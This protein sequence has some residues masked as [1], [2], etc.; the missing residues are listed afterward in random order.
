M[1]TSVKLVVLYKDSRREE[2]VYPVV[3]GLLTVPKEAFSAVNYIEIHAAEFTAKIGD[4]GYFLVPN[5]A[6]GLDN[7][8]AAITYFR[9]REDVVQDFPTSNMPLYAACD[10][11]RT[12]LAICDGMQ[13]EYWLEMEV[14]DGIYRVFPRF[15]IQDVDFYEDITIRFYEWEGTDWFAVARRYRRHQLDRGVCLPLRERV[16]T[17]DV[18]RA[19]VEGIDMRCKLSGKIPDEGDPVPGE[20]TEENEPPLRVFTDFDRMKTL[21]T[22]MKAEGCEH[23]NLCLVGWNS[24]GMDGRNP[25]YMPPEPA[26]GGEAKLRELLEYAKREGY[27]VGAHTNP[28]ISFTVSKRLDKNDWQMNPDGSNYIWGGIACCS[29]GTPHVLCDKQSYENYVLQD[30]KDMVELGFRGVHFCDQIN[31]FK[32]RTC[33]H[34]EHPINKRQSAEYRSK[35]L[36]AMREATGAS[37]SEGGFDFCIGSYD[38]AMYPVIGY[39]PLPSICDETVPLWFAVYHGIVTYN[40]SCKTVNAIF[41]GADYELLMVEMGAK[42]L[43]YLNARV[44]EY[45][46]EPN[47]MVGTDEELAAGAKTLGEGYRRYAALVDLQYE[48]MEDYKRPAEGVSVVRY[49]N[50]TAIVVNYTDAPYDYEGQVVPAKSYRRIDP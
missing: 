1:L 21:V 20:Q 44:F 22:A 43:A 8:N 37:S 31:I 9:Q 2:R 6:R 15:H 16:K 7:E 42:P 40:V 39:V 34:P 25:D 36:Q 32:P 13:H 3:D 35:M 47:L 33:Y 46:G 50:G 30:A 10:G 45:E 48:F 29:G 11:K 14:R 23:A 27:L 49:G 12:V 17:N 28:M 4:E 41:K 38:W 24:G 5:I 18:L 26:L 19:A